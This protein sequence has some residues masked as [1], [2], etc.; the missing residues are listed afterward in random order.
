MYGINCEKIQLRPTE[1]AVLSYQFR[2]GSKRQ[3]NTMTV[4]MIPLHMHDQSRLGSHS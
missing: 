4:L 2:G 3:N 1:S